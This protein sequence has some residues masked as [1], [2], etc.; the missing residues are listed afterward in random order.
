LLGRDGYSAKASDIFM[1]GGASSGVNTLL[2]IICADENTGILIPIPQYP[3]Y[4]ATLSLL[5]AKCVPYYLDSKEGWSVDVGTV[6]DAYENATAR[7]IDVRAIVVINPGNPTGAVLSEKNIKGIIDYAREKR[8]VIIA[9]E[10][11]QRNVF[12]KEFHSFKKVLCSMQ[13]TD[14]EK[15][16]HIELASLHSVS[17]GLI[18][19]CGHRGGFFELVGFDP[20]VQAEIYKFISIMLCPSVIGQ[21]LV[22]LMVNPP[23]EGDLSYDQFEEESMAILEDMKNRARTLHGV[24]SREGF[25]CNV[26]EGSMY[27]FPSVK[28]PPKAAQAAALEGRSPDEFYCLKLLEATGVCVVPGSG[29]GQMEGSYNFRTTFLAQGTEWADR[30]VSFHRRFMDQY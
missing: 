20:R 14:P 13:A 24:F 6:K 23:Q 3:L 27:L 30:I 17:K 8:L 16:Q 5:G 15:F 9:D 22:S 1:C 25:E 19:E 29:F 10:V 26:P 2:H 11:Y 7:D 18:G 21:C 12:T 28:I 4:T